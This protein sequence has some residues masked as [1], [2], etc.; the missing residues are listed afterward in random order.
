MI[1]ISF[2]SLFLFLLSFIITIILFLLLV[3]LPYFVFI[4]FSRQLCVGERSW[5]SFGEIYIYFFL[6]F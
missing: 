4:F 3:V 6:I 5:D 2:L 1:L